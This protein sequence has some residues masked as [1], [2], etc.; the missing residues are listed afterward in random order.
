MFKISTIKIA[1]AGVLASAYVLM[2]LLTFPIASGAVQIRLSEALTLMPLIMP[3]SIVSLF[4]GCIISNLIT[5]CALLD[6]IFGSIITLLAGIL[7]S[8]IGKFIKN[9]LLKIL[10]GGVFPVLLNAVFLPLIW[11]FCYGQLE[12]VYILQVVFL[13]V[14]QA[15]SVYALGIPLFKGIERLNIV[16]KKT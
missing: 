16:K 2:S 3:E 11:Y 15:L 4:V 1:R 14:S 12:Y 13:F 8:F 9:S 10:V 7:T 6:I 5:G